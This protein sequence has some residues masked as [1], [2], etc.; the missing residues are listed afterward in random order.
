MASP[1]PKPLLPAISAAP[2]VDQ[3]VSTGCRVHSD[4]PIEVM[5][6][7]RPSAHIHDVVCAGVAPSACAAAKTMATELVKPTSTATKPATTAD[8]DRSFQ[9]PRIGDGQISTLEPSS[10]MRLAGRFRKSAAAAALR[11]MPAKSFSRHIAMP[12]PKVG[13]TLSRDRK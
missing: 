5:P 4:S 13:M 3:A 10:T 6:M 1:M 12:S 9:K 8:S 7:P 11:C 2:G